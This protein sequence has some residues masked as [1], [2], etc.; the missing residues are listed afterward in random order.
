[1]VEKCVQLTLS[2]QYFGRHQYGVHGLEPYRNFFD[3]VQRFCSDVGLKESYG[4]VGN[5]V[6]QIISLLNVKSLF[7]EQVYYL[8]A[9]Y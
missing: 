7:H 8:G 4:F 6:E 3:I 2:G 1:M 9:A 5:S